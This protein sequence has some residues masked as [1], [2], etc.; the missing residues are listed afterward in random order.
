M[1]QPAGGLEALEGHGKRQEAMGD[2]RRRHNKRRDGNDKEEDGNN[3]V[4]D[5]GGSAIVQ[6]G[7]Y[8][9]DGMAIW[10]PSDSRT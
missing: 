1:Q 4:D 7:L 3:V 9:N 5:D 6:W 2:E 10:V 8:D